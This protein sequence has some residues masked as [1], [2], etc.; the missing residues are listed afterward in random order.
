[1]ACLAL[2]QQGRFKRLACMNEFRQPA[3]GLCRGCFAF[4][5][6]LH[7]QHFFGCVLQYGM[8]PLCALGMRLYMVPPRWG[9]FIGFSLAAEFC[10]RKTRSEEHTSELQS[11]M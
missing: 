4:F 5:R 2:H 1:M 6:L 3:R 10:L 11:L 7:P 8:K 9:D